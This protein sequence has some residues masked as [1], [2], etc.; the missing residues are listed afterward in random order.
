MTF[1]IIKMNEAERRIGLTVVSLSAEQERQRLE[2]YHRQA[3]E[4]TH[5]IEEAIHAEQP[6]DENE[7]TDQ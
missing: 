7:E 2:D 3:S 4:A 6:R 5:G 1:K